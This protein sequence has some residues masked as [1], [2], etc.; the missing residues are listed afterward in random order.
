MRLQIFSLVS[1]FCIGG[2]GLSE[3]QVQVDTSG[4][5]QMTGEEAETGT[6]DGFL[7]KVRSQKPHSDSCWNIH[8]AGYAIQY[9]WS[10]VGPDPSFR[11]IAFWTRSNGHEETVPAHVAC[12][13]I[14]VV[15]PGP[16]DT[17]WYRC[18]ASAFVGMGR[19]GTY[20]VE[21]APVRDGKWD[22]A[23]LGRNYVF[24]L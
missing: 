1:L 10:E 7:L 24:S 23:G 20:Q 2:C 21:I 22:T 14:F 3:S 15:R 13:E 8:M 5:S 17:R 11:N 19:R 18:V 9:S 4:C 12:E 16:S 6:V